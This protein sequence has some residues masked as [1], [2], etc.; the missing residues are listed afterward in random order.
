MTQ[1]AL[2]ANGKPLITAKSIKK[3]EAE[4]AKGNMQGLA[5]ITAGLAYAQK[6]EAK[7][8]AIAYA[9]QDLW[10]KHNINHGSQEVTLIPPPPKGVGYP[11]PEDVVSKPVPEKAVQLDKN[12]S[13]TAKGIPQI[14]LNDVHLLEWVANKGDAEELKKDALSLA[15]SQKNAAKKLALKKA[16]KQLLEKLYAHQGNPPNSGPGHP[17]RGKSGSA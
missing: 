6:T 15:S 1:V 11:Q 3:L 13:G 4:A 5:V 2:G 12:P 17:D 10:N 16:G 9:A 7:K 8:W 14:T